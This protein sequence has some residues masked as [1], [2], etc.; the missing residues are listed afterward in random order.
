MKFHHVGIVVDKIEK[1]IPFIQTILKTESVTI[2]FQDKIQKVNVSFIN[3]GN[4]YLE[5]IEPAQEQTPVTSFLNKR[6]GGLHHLGFEVD[7][8][9]ESASE[10]QKKGGK[11]VCEPVRGFEGRLI[12]F[13]FFTSLPFNLI[14][15]ISKKNIVK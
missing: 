7:D 14:E 10:L 12:S 11:V 3:I 8:I 2:P 5:L 6:G 13:I 4:F 15:I 9:F 1:Y